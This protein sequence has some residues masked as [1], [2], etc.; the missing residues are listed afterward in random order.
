MESA[1]LPA[2][3]ARK[4][5]EAGGYDETEIRRLA[6]EYVALDLGTSLE[7]FLEWVRSGPRR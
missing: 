4:S 5:L 1:R 3:Q 2:N 6:D 7:G